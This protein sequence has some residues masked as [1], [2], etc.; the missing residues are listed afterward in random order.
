MSE[1]TQNIDS[2]NE[3]AQIAGKKI[4]GNSV[5]Q[6]IEKEMGP[7]PSHNVQQENNAMHSINV[8]KSN[9]AILRTGYTGQY[10]TILTK[11]NNKF[12]KMMLSKEND[13]IYYN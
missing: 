10:A 4:W 9:Y 8:F 11:I 7:H 13:T 1:D 5:T 12:I 2:K 3:I 6:F